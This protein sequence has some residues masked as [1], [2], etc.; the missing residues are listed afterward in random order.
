VK[1]IAVIVLSLA[2]LITG[3]LRAEKKTDVLMKFS[4]Q[5]DLMRIVFESEDTFMKDAKSTTTPFQIKVEFP[6]LFHLPVENNLPFEVIV[7]DRSA[8]I[9]LKEKNEIKFFTLSSPARLVFDIQKKGTQTEKQLEKPAEKQAEKQTGKQPST[10][11]PIIPMVFIIDAGHGGYD[12]GITSGNT[13]EKE[14][15]LKLA[16][17]LNAALSKKGKKVFL[18]RQAD[19]YLSLSER[20]YFVN[21]KHPDIFISLHAST[22]GNFVLY[23]P[24]LEE[25]SSNEPVDLYSVSSKQSKYIG[26]SRA[27]SE[28]IEKAIKNEFKMNIQRRELSLPLLDAAS[29]PAVFMEYPSPQFLTYDQQTKTR[30]INALLTG[31]AAYG[32]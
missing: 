21:Q 22:S 19:Q 25:Q 2:L 23:S 9:N 24:K 11:I 26:K 15:S 17:E 31:L 10:I 16:K 8:V 29:A 5:G 6:G 27:L 32:Q 18:I 20:I 3:S 7:T 30:L 14:I 28:S 1:R 13:S 12:F 4:R